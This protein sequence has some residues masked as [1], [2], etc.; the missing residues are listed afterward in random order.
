[1]PT[2]PHVA[3]GVLVG[4]IGA[5]APLNVWCVHARLIGRVGRHVLPGESRVISFREGVLQVNAAPSGEAKVRWRG[6]WGE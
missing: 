1:M 2:F 4:F 5:H 6:G 3:K